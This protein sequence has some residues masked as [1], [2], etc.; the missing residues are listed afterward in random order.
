MSRGYF[1]CQFHPFQ[2]FALLF[3]VDILF[4]QTFANEAFFPSPAIS[5]LRL[6]LSSPADAAYLRRR[7]SAERPQVHAVAPLAQLPDPVQV[8]PFRLQEATDQEREQGLEVHLIRTGG[9][10]IGLTLRGFADLLHRSTVVLG[11]AGTANEQGAG[12]GRVVV[13]LPRPGV[14][15]TNRFAR[16][17]PS[18]LK[19]VPGI[20]AL[21]PGPAE[22]T[23]PHPADEGAL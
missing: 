3:I 13:T 15:Y 20:G 2:A 19:K 1:L 8:C 16:R 17:R 10:R 22:P 14:Q 4:S 9:S 5:C 21:Q 23:P 11:L 6:A 18:R 12:L 7:L